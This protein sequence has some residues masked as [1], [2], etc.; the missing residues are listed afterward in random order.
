MPQGQ[1]E[2]LGEVHAEGVV[3]RLDIVG[4]PGQERLRVVD[5]KT[6]RYDEK[7]LSATE[8]DV[9]EDKEKG[10]VLQ[11]LLYAAAVARTTRTKLPIEPNLFFCTK[12]MRG[13]QTTVTMGDEP[14]T[15]Y[16]KASKSFEEGLQKLVQTIYDDK[17]FEKQGEK[18]CSTYCPFLLLCGRK[19][20][21]ED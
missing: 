5:Y 13:L 21:R 17:Q 6:G 18:T 3:D 14:V 7:K 11:T 19:V 12:D 8:K 9:F 20:E 16:K 10:Y 2:G 4:L 1:I 15:D